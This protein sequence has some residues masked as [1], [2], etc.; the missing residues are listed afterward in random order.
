MLL[1]SGHDEAVANWASER[2]GMNFI[3]PYS[4]LAVIDD[5]GHMRGAAIWNDF[6]GKGGNVELSYLGPVTKGVVQQ[7]AKYAFEL[8]GV[9]RVTL[10]TRK[11]NDRA[12]RVLQNP[13]HGFEYEGTRKRYWAT[14]KDGDA[15][16][17]VLFAGKA[18]KW[19]V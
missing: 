5:E 1:V 11:S 14:A 8:L 16:S 15:L 17:F 18:K 19:L 7:L 12:R 10:K 2:V 3:Q 9:S 13:H 4:A 6:H